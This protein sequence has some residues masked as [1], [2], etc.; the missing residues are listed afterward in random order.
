MSTPRPLPVELLRE[1]RNVAALLRF[2]CDD[3]DWPVAVSD[4]DALVEEDLDE[5]AWDWDPGE[6]GVLDEQVGRL[7]R[8]RELRPLTASQPWGIFILEFDGEKIPVVQLRRI[9]KSLVRTRRAANNPSWRTWGCDDLLFIV[10]SG[11]ADGADIHMLTFWEREDRV[12]E[13]RPLTWP[14]VSRDR[15]LHRLANDL[16]PHLRWPEDT[17]DTESWR[18]E[19]RK[20]F[21]LPLGA[22]ISSAASLAER[23]AATARSLRDQIATALADENGSGPFNELLSEVR[24]QLVADADETKFADMCAQTL[25]YGLLSSRVTDPEG[26]G[27]SPVY[28]AVPLANPFLAAFFDKVQ[29]EAYDLDMKGAGVEKLVADLRQTNVEAILDQFG[30][31]AKGGDPVIHF[32]ED[33]LTQYNPQD[34]LDAG[35]FYTPQLAVEFIVR[36]VDE[37]LRSRFHLDMGV[38]DGSSWQQV[39]N[40]NGF[41]VPEGVDPNGRFVSMIDPATGTGTFLVEWLRRAKASYDGC[42]DGHDWPTHLRDHVLESMHAFELMLAPYAI[43]HLK[44]ALEL[45]ETGL[46]DVGIQILLTDT[47]DHAPPQGQFA[48][49]SDPVA[50]EGQRAAAL[51]RSERFTVVIGNPPYDREQRAVGHTGKRKGG[52]VRYGV[53]G[54]APLIED[55]TEPM[56]AA[57]QGRHLKNI[58]NDYVYFWRWAMWQAT[59]LPEGPGVVAFITAASYLDGVSM[60][61]LRHLLRATFDELWI[62]DLGG[63]GRGARTEENIFDIQTPVAVAVGCRTGMESTDDCTVRYLRVT[64]TRSEKLASLKRL[65]LDAV[66]EEVPGFRLDRFTPGSDLAYFDWPQ[67]SD[68]FPWIHSGCQ[69]KRLW[70]ISESRQLLDRRWQ[71]LLTTSTHQRSAL[72]SQTG[73]RRTDSKLDNLLSDGSKLPPIDLLSVGDRHEGIERYGYRSFDREWIIADA[74]VI[75]APKRPF[76]DIRGAHQ[77]F[78]TTLTTA[79]LSQGPALVAGPYVPDLDHRTA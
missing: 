51:K 27:A 10:T 4:P 61:G 59:E 47:L 67:V 2:L 15:R 58:Y 78:L 30:N 33:F 19:W 75:D 32:Y 36:A 63:E 21:R 8:L 66:H 1:I 6:L 73:S 46:S 65:T 37:V 48:V 13:I 28:S 45:Q 79:K 16:L 56:K 55:I 11:E 9:L 29:E 54:I 76:W 70:P 38:A 18:E 69:V 12:P 77:V 23:M 72:L 22:A 60:G 40:R 17:S 26:F 52:I 68:L 71:V 31:T 5:L 39:A 42:N 43:A 34:R 49:V 7:R 64:G 3:L 50:D 24:Q 41:N 25:V 57:D 14:Q 44:V 62:I 53:P 74:R 35:A 20:A